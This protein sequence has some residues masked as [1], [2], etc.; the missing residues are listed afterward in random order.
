MSPALTTASSQ[1][2]ADLQISH[3]R[4]TKD[5]QRVRDI[6]QRQDKVEELLPLLKG[7]LPAAGLS[8]SVSGARRRIATNCDETAEERAS[9]TF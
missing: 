5:A 6:A 7:L 9:A 4:Q 1:K 8:K 2:C 3:D